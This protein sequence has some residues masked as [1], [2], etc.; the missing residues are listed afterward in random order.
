M[1]N[2]SV[3]M[4]FIWSELCMIY[5]IFSMIY[6]NSLQRCL[7]VENREGGWSGDLV[8]CTVWVGAIDSYG[9]GKK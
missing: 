4:G 8:G 6:V 1:G 2:A 7:T 5:T 9:Y 3:A